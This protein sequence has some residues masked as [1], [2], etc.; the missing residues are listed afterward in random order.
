[1]KALKNIFESDL[2]YFSIAFKRIE[3][4]SSLVQDVLLT[5]LNYYYEG[6]DNLYFYQKF[7]WVPVKNF[8][9]GRS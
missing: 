1:M 6:S 8:L 2:S 9:R 7:V 3:K 4:S 5:I